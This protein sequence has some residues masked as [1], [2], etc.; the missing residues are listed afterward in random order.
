M[1]ALICFMTIAC[2]EMRAKNDD[3]VLVCMRSER[4]RT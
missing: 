2:D 4:A 1:I 3:W